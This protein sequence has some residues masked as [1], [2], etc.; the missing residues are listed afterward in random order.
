MSRP[1][2]NQD[3]PSIQNRYPASSTSTSPSNPP[4]STSKATQT[5]TSSH[6]EH[7]SQNW[8]QFKKSHQESH[9]LGPSGASSGYRNKGGDLLDQASGMAQKAG[10]NPKIQGQASGRVAASDNQ[11]QGSVGG[12]WGHANFQGE[13]HFLEAQGQVKGEAGIRGANVYAHGEASFSANLARI[14]GKGQVKINGVGELNVQ[15]NV[16]IGANGR[17]YGSVQIGKDGVYAEVGGKAFVGVE[18]SVSG[19]W[20]S[21]NGATVSASAAFKAGIG[22]EGSAKV[23]FKDGKLNLKIDFGIALGVG[24]RIS[25][26]ISIDFNKLGKSITD[27]FSKL[28]GGGGDKNVDLSKMLKKMSESNPDMFKELMKVMDGA[29]K[30]LSNF[31][32]DNSN[33][34]NNPNKPTSDTKTEPPP[35]QT[36]A[37]IATTSTEDNSTDT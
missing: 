3:S 16:T 19:T 7:S 30:Q 21:D 1:I 15:G 37:H 8:S 36:S 10:F 26:D 22:I 17:A 4:T 18:A 27:F 2:T 6:F 28:F 25:L 5:S 29:T 23:G 12:D 24:F 14:E 32:T 11:F 34:A 13:A 35:P 33:K 9:Q 31:N 20:K